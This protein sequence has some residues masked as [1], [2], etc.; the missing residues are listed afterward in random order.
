MIALQDIYHTPQA[1][2]ILWQLML[3]RSEEDQ[4]NISFTMPRR[5]E[6]EAYVQRTPY[7]HW[8]LAQEGT[9]WLGSVSVTWRNEVGIVLFQDCRGRGYGKRVLEEFLRAV[10]PLPAA[11][12]ERPGYFV[13]NINPEN[14]RSIRLFQ[15][16]GFELIQHTYARKEKT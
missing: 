13:A 4:V 7:A 12:G 15:S 8:F 9:E 1:S 6:H 5:E 11:P 2:E 14:A 3:E 10:V 16:L